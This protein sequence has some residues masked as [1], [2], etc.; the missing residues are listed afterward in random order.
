MVTLRFA[1]EVIDAAELPRPKGRDL[2]KEEIKMAE[3]LVHALEGEFNPVEFHDQYRERV[4]ELVETKARGG[5]IKMEKPRERKAEVISLTDMLKQSI[6]KVRE[7][8]K[9]A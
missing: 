5:K 7:E 1:R 4:L 2:L 3:Q 9:V 8:R 6:K